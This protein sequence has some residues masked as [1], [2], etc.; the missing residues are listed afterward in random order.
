[1][2]KLMSSPDSKIWSRFV[3]ELVIWLNQVAFVSWTQPSG[4]ITFGEFD[5]ELLSHSAYVKFFVTFSTK[6]PYLTFRNKM[7]QWIEREEIQR[8]WGNVES[9][10]LSSF[11]LNFLFIFSFTLHFLIHS[12]VSHSQAARLAKLVQPCFCL[13]DQS[14]KKAKIAHTESTHT[15]IAQRQYFKICVNKAW[16]INTKCVMS[17]LRLTQPPIKYANLQNLQNAKKHGFRIHWQKINT[18]S[19]KNS[20]DGVWAL[21]QQCARSRWSRWSR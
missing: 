3:F 7:R 4:R 9:E 21:F 15:K 8:K 1:M 16:I 11:S 13:M 20:I 2:L 6:V 19:P 5:P 10:S 12:P 17:L 14:K 18:A